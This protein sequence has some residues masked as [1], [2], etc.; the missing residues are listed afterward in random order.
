MKKVL[1]L[2]C[3]FGIEPLYKEQYEIAD[4]NYIVDISNAENELDWTPF[5]SDSDMLFAAYKA[6]KIS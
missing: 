3:C 4:E 6:Y 1:F 5:D 2:L